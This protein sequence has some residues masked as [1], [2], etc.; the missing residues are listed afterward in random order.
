VLVIDA[1]DTFTEMIGH[2]LR[3]LGLDVTLRRFDEDYSFDGYDAVVMGPGPGDPRA[4]EHP[5]IAHLRA[6]I[7]ILLADR[8]P[9]LAV[10]LSH[11]ALSVRLGLDLVRREN[12]NQGTQLEIDLFGE[13]QMV[14]FYNTFAAVAPEDKLDCAGVG[15]VELSRDPTTGEVH[16]LRGPHFAALQFHAESVLTKNGPDI[17]GARMRE[18]LCG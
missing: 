12:P 13:R 10:C 18:L 17:L 2:Q 7:D 9:F 11:Q 1:E 3:S 15:T 6:A 16:A 14:G 5:K 8:I 4:E